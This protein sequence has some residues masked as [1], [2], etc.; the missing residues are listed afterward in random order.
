MTLDASGNLLVGNTDTDP[1]TN[2]VNGVAITAS[3]EVIASLNGAAAQFNRRISN[4]DIAVFK[5]GGSTVGSI[6]SWDQSGTSRVGFVNND[7]NGLGIYRSNSTSVK[8][9]PLK[10]GALDDGTAVDLGNTNARFKDLYLSGGAYLG[11][12]GSANLLDDY[13]QGSWTPAADFA[14]T[15]PTSGASTGA[16]R[17]TKVGNVVTVWGTV[18]NLNVTG[19]SGDLKIT[20][21]PFAARTNTSLQRYNGIIRLTNCDFSLFTDTI[22]VSAQVLDGASAV[23]ASIIRDNLSSD[24]VGAS[25]LDDGVSDLSVTL[26]YETDD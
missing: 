7:S 26:T 11:G 6:N 17:Y 4:G 12:T 9:V 24:N 5:Q 18:S 8:I 1:A 15:S 14:T 25:A 16:G 10:T 2:N 19:A 23:N 13:E 20:G 3:G 21:L 22:Q